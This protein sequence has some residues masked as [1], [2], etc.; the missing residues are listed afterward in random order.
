MRTWVVL[1]LTAMFVMLRSATADEIRSANYNLLA[2]S[3]ADNGCSGNDCVAVVLIHGIH[4]TDNDPKSSCHLTDPAATDCYWKPLIDHLRTQPSVWKKIRIYIF[5]YLSNVPDTSTENIGNALR[6]QI[7]TP[8]VDCVN[9]QE[10]KRPFIFVA[11]SMGGIVARQ[12]MNFKPVSSAQRGA[13]LVLGAITLATPHQGTPLAN[14]V[15]RDNKVE[16]LAGEKANSS[17]C[18]NA[19][20]GIWYGIMLPKN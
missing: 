3:G 12:F 17:G 4:G 14:R 2:L 16:R 9:C 20:L 19:I 13:D 18:Y 10:L 5:R 6:G 1:G 11:H 7:D 8:P 15:L